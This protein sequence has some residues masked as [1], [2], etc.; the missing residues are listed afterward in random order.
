M[1]SGVSWRA[2]AR[3]IGANAARFNGD[4]NAGY[5]TATVAGLDTSKSFSVAAWVSPA[6]I[7]TGN[8]T[9]VAQDSGN[10]SGFFLG[11]RYL[12]GDSVPRWAFMILNS[13]ASTCGTCAMVYAP[14]TLG[15]ADVNRWVYLVGVFDAAASTVNLY[16]NGVLV[17]TTT[18]TAEPWKADGPLTIGRAQWNGS[19]SDGFYGGIA[20][21][22]VWNRVVMQDD[23]WGTD[24]DEASGVP[25][26]AGLMSPV[27][28]GSWD[29][30]GM[31][32]CGCGGP[33]SDIGYFGRALYLDAG[34]ANATPTSGFALESHDGNGAMWTD[35]SVGFASTTDPDTGLAQ[36]VL[37]T[38]QSYSVSA[39]V[40]LSSLPAHNATILAQN[41]TASGAF[42]LQYNYTHASTPG[43]EFKLSATDTNSASVAG[44]WV[45]GATTDWTHL[46][47]VYDVETGTAR[48]YVNGLLVGTMSALPSFQAS[49][50]LTVS[51]AMWNTRMDDPVPGSVD[52]VQVWQGVLSD[53]E[54]ADLYTNS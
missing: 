31:A 26:A 28:V 3:Y 16:V 22:R 7:A 42:F 9:A 50:P 21:V 44:P 12:A 19:P 20:D 54:V 23:L 13:S 4:S 47:G 53:R 6:S 25:A 18:R 40:K 39:W 29:F 11:S 32:D 46:V 41:G 37:R 52:Q 34:W 36:P 14:T 15:S 43:W 45:G 1:Q 17:A 2:D 30:N 38:D 51:G 27:Q 49:G 35:G 8:R 33:S 5:A 48:L 10:A 24:A